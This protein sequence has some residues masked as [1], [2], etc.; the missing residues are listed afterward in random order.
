MSEWKVRGEQKAAQ[1]EH[2][3]NTRATILP[4]L[5]KQE[6]LI[7]MQSSAGAGTE[8]CN[9]LENEFF[10]LQSQIAFPSF[11]TLTAGGCASTMRSFSARNSHH[12]DSHKELV[13]SQL[14]RQGAHSQQPNLPWVSPK[15]AAP[16]C[17]QSL[18]DSEPPGS[19]SLV[20][21]NHQSGLLYQHHILTVLMLS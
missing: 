10:P 9:H 16:R 3:G 5:K 21:G 13:T 18:R 15:T 14:P 17:S 12:S 2:H 1:S 7:S 4:A 8:F 20:A 11:V 19:L 6:T